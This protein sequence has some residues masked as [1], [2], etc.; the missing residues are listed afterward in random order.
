MTIRGFLTLATT[1]ALA[2]GIPDAGWAQTVTGPT[3]TWVA[4]APV[5]DRGE[6]IRVAAAVDRVSGNVYE[7]RSP[8]TSD[9]ATVFA[10]SPAGDLLWSHVIADV[11]GDAYVAVDPGSGRVYVAL[12]KKRESQ[13][14]GDWLTVAYDQ[15]GNPLWLRTF[16]T[17]VE[18]DTPYGL[19][20]DPLTGGV[21]VT[22]R[23]GSANATVAYGPAGR[24]VW[25]RRDEASGTASGITYSPS[26]NAVVLVV[27]SNTTLSVD[28]AT[29]ELRWQNTT[30]V[31]DVRAVVVPAVDPARGTVYVTRTVDPDAGGPDR[32]DW[33]TQAIN[34]EGT[35]LWESALKGPSEAGVDAPTGVAVDATSGNAYVVGRLQEAGGSRVDTYTVAYGATG[36]TLWTAR[37]DAAGMESAG[38]VVV[39]PDDGEVYI[40]SCE[41]QALSVIGYSAGGRTDWVSRIALDSQFANCSRDLLV[42]DARDQLLVPFGVD[43]FQGRGV[44]GPV[45]LAYSTAPRL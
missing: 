5:Q 40:T 14:I 20:A 12:Q 45:V 28:A 18:S 38:A 43:P 25:Q 4:G 30:S 39:D 36:Q 44:V 29:G 10:V 26:Q 6:S 24:P 41:E 2:W 27:G 7:V 42:D 37:Y 33:A 34:A 21:V 31:P 35:T 16:G 22:G 3:P 32:G 19:V 23:S 15:L 17:R 11:T 9:R 8:R 13:G 1:A